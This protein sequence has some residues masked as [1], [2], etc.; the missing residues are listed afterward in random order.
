MCN[1]KPILVA[2]KQVSNVFCFCRE[3]TAIGIFL[4]R[5]VILLESIDTSDIVRIKELFISFPGG[6]HDPNCFGARYSCAA[7]PMKVRY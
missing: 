6:I 5:V 3:K 7:K 2:V 1:A 4:A